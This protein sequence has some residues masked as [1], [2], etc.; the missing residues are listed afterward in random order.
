[1]MEQPLP[2]KLWGEPWKQPVP[3]DF[4]PVFF[5]DERTQAIFKIVAEVHRGE[6]VCPG[7][8]VKGTNEQELATEFI[9]QMKI[10]VQSGDWSRILSPNRHFV[11]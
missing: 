11:W 7:L 2:K 3:L 1:M 8:Q 10:S 4:I 5:D 9:A 6:L